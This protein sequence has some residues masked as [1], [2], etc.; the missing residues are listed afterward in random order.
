M[1][2]VRQ[3]RHQVKTDLDGGTLE[4]PL[5]SVRQRDIN[6][7][8][9]ERSIS[10]VQLPFARRDIVQHGLELSLGL[11]PDGEVADELVRVTGGKADLEL[12]AE[13][14]VDG[15]HKVEDA[16]NLAFDLACAGTMLAKGASARRVRIP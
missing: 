5:Q 13:F 9:V 14:A 10:L 7:R 12:H 6:L 11:V 1:K 8:S 3:A 2:R 16:G 15:V 4:L